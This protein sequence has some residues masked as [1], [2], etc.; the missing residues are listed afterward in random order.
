MA[1]R[2]ISLC[3]GIG[4]LDAGVRLAIDTRTVCY[5]ERDS[6][7]AA[8]LVARMQEGA[9]DDAP[10]WDDI[11]TFDARPW[12][13][14]VDLV[15]GGF[16]CQPFSLAGKGLGADDPRHLFHHV[17]RVVSECRPAVC[18][19]ENVPGL[20]RRGLEQVRADL[21]GMG[22]HVA[23]GTFS[24]EDVG[25]SHKRER[26]FILAVA[27]GDLGGREAVGRGWLPDGQRAALRDDSYRRDGESAVADADNARP[28]GRVLIID[29]QGEL[30]PRES[31]TER[32][33]FAPGREHRDWPA[34]LKP[35]ICRVAH[36]PSRRMVRP[37][38]TVPR[39]RALGNA[40]VP[41]VAAVAFRELWRRMT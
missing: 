7:C 26:L 9:L 34:G 18:F 6:Y 38:G 23:A 20:I 29:G 2:T 25:A 5:V 4:G 10:I 13:G 33:L 40:V 27:D 1:L 37:V 14:V 15:I 24:A 19:F 35:A 17:A 8:T 32:S 11:S 36:G 41:V 39:L 21:R 22:Y 16:P 12:R 28:Q 30:P 31:G 3:A